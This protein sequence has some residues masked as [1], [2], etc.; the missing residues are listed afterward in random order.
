MSRT[1]LIRRTLTRSGL[2]LAAAVA[3]IASIAVG[4]AW[5]ASGTEGAAEALVGFGLGL[6]A[7]PIGYRLLGQSEYR[8]LLTAASPVHPLLKRLMTEAPG[9]YV[10]SLAAA[11]LSEA[12]AEV[13]GADPLLARVGA[14]YHDIG[15][16]SAP[17]FF[18]ENQEEGVNPHDETLPSR[19]AKIITSHVDD[20]VALAKE[21]GLPPGVIDIVR[22]HHGTALVR[23]FYHKASQENAALY[24]ADFRY[25]GGIPRSK[26]AAIVMLADASEASVRAMTRPASSDVEAIV[27]CVIAERT[28]D[29]QLAESGL[30]QSDLDALVDAFTRYLVSLRHAR[31]P[32][33][34]SNSTGPLEGASRA[35][36]RAEPSRA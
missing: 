17:C 10:H 13:V 7:I 29:G 2:L 36:Q 28:E 33:P 35:D 12:A 11:N 18:F 4:I 6:I 19:S 14:Y 31:C 27:R 16:L 25:R 23:Y 32:Y 34:E 26:E 22:E 24:E 30:T 8:K 20:G 3:G 1:R 21:Y 5:I 15:K 9:T